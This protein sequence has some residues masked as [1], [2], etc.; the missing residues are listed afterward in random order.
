MGYFE[1]KGAKRGITYFAQNRTESLLYN[2]LRSIEGDNSELLILYSVP[3]C[4][5]EIKG[6]NLSYL[7]RAI[8]KDEVSEVM[9]DIES[10]KINEMNRG[11]SIY[12]GGIFVSGV[13]IDK[14]EIKEVNEIG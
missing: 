6:M 12:Q 8:L 7:R 9:T 11:G 10:D 1:Y 2:Y 4:A 14:I 3:L 5:V 13:S